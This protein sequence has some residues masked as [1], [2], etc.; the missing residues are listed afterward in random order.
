[1]QNR[2][3][4]SSINNSDA[5]ES[6]QISYNHNERNG[7]NISQNEYEALGIAASGSYYKDGMSK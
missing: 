3:R 7:G 5:Q 2:N 1:M 4:S 6:S